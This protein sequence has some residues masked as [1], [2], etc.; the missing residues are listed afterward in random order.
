MWRH[1]IL[2]MNC[3]ATSDC[4]WSRAPM[5]DGRHQSQYWSKL[6]ATWCVSYQQYVPFPSLCSHLCAHPPTSPSILVSC[7]DP[8]EKRK[9]GL[10]LWTTFLVTWVGS[11]GIKNV[12]IA[13]PIHCM[14]IRS[15][16]QLLRHCINYAFC[17]LIWALRLGSCDMKSR[18]EHQTLSHMWRV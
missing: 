6:T 16:A 8:P 5:G 11:N 10:V 4:V 7:P 2:S 12:I 1:V 18:S 17:N 15:R 9:E 3:R 14:H 13:F